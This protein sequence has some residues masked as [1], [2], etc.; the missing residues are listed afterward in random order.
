MDAVCE[1]D[2]RRRVPDLEAHVETQP[3]FGPL[4]GLN[5]A[6]RAAHVHS[7]GLLAIDVLTR[8][9]HRLQVLRVEVRRRG[10]HDRVH[11]LRAGDLLVSVG[12]EEHLRPIDAGV[13][14]RLGEA[15]KVLLRILQLVLKQIRQR[16]D[17]RRAGLGQIGRV[18]AASS[19][20]AEQPHPHGRVRRRAAHQSRA[21]DHQARSSCGCA[22]EFPPVDL[23]QSLRLLT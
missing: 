15:V 14:F 21:D 16:D 13:T 9:D 3:P 12:T 6:L 11:F 22:H 5:D 10:N 4:A 23:L 20:A 18:R 2:K 8:R 7:H 1:L 17:P 19:T